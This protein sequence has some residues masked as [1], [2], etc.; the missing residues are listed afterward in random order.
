MN[1]HVYICAMRLLA[2]G[3]LLMTAGPFHGS[4][5]A[6]EEIR[7]AFYWGSSEPESEPRP[8]VLDDT[9]A[10]FIWDG[11]SYAIY[12]TNAPD[13]SARLVVEEVIAELAPGLAIDCFH[14]LTTGSWADLAAAG[15]GDPRGAI[16]ASFSPRELRLL[17]YAPPSPACPDAVDAGRL[18]TMF[19]ADFEHPAG[20]RLELRA[21]WGDSAEGV[22][23]GLVSDS[24]AEWKNGNL[25]FSVASGGHD[26]G[27][28][29]VTAIA[30]ALDPGFEAAC[31][32]RIQTLNDAQL[33]A[34][35]L[36]VPTVPP[37]FQR[38]SSRQT[39][40]LSPGGCSHGDPDPGEIELAWVFRSPGNIDLEVGVSRGTGS[41]SDASQA[42]VLIGEDYVR[43][44]DAQG[45]AYYVYGHAPD[46]GPGMSQADLFAVARSLDPS[47]PIPGR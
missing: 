26:L 2:V 37:G 45:T 47:V 35:G 8:N 13:M 28:A 42:E 38:L 12:A 33:A 43:W 18:P 27:E 15:L 46:E 1:K 32:R 40:R 21:D 11:Q 6:A 20:H 17:Y 5:L 34:R 19:F 36:R 9:S 39:A 23:P 16:P 10:S 29:V 14:R 31:H 25:T 41:T 22:R 44:T 24:G 7:G 3:A 30:G 4:A